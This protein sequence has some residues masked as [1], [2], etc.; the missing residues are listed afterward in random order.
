MTYYINN[1]S[2]GYK[3]EY[4][5]S[6]IKSITLESGEHGGP[7]PAGTP[8]K[9]AGLNVELN[10]PPLFYMDSS[11]SGGFY[12]C[13][14][15]TEDR[16]A[17]Q[18]FVHH[19]GGHPKVLGLQL[20][21]LVSLE[22]FQ[23]RFSFHGLATTMPPPISPAVPFIPR[24]A[25][26][27]NHFAATAP[28]IGAFQ[29]SRLAM[30]M[31]GPR[32][33]K[34][35][36]SRSVP[37]AVDF[38]SMQHLYPPHPYSMQQAPPH[39]TTDAG[40]FAPVPQATHALATNNLRL[41]TSSPYSIGY[42]LSAPPP[43]SPSDLTNSSLFTPGTSVETPIGP[44]V[45][46][47][48]KMPYVSPVIDTSDVATHTASPYAAVTPVDSSLANNSPPL[49]GMPGQPD[50]FSIGLEPHGLSDDNGM[51]FSKQNANFPVSPGVGIAGGATFDL[52]IHSP[53]STHREFAALDNVDPNA[54][55]HAS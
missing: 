34:R 41:D 44:N 35:Q 33:H 1:D 49:V 12:Q 6:H 21:K 32:G 45:G 31:Q 10:Q 28:F 20:S 42:P 47:P 27:P 53:P 39:F 14:D 3:I 40:I 30:D 48:F 36:R 16:Q 8:P 17:S 37:V 23:N 51:I 18:I 19:L 5:F 2:A 29:D 7:Q 4:P 26:Q 15:F 22:S 38:P 24:P 50:M 25:S 13:G 11:N 54:L 55:S 43:T 9:P 52:P 46:N